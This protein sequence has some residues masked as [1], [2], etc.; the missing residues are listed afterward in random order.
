MQPTDTDP[1]QY[2]VD[3]IRKAW[4]DGVVDL[5]NNSGDAPLRGIYPR[6]KASLSRIAGT[7]ILYERES[8]LVPNSD[9]G[10]R[11]YCLFFVSPT[12]ERF[13]FE[14]E[15]IEPDEAGI[16]RRFPGQGWI[17]CLV[18][19]SVVAP[20]AAVSLDEMEVYENGSRLEPDVEPHIFTLDMGKM[21]LESH[22]GEMVDEE[23]LSIL[24]KLRAAIARVLAES[25]IAVI[26]E[27]DLDSPVP[28]LRAG[29]RSLVG[30]AGEPIT[31]RQAFFFRGL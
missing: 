14:T 23:G 29:E 21:D 8:Q 4:P 7:R 16:E 22:F 15:T 26:P 3:A 5:P 30:Q 9:E 31:V 6:L 20:F 12:D 11:S 18:A 19:I 17:G 13:E 10:S 25:E 1:P 2:I 24:R 28:W 27:A